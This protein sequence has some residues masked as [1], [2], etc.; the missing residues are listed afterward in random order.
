MSETFEDALKRGRESLDKMK[1]GANYD[2]YL[3]LKSE[4]EQTKTDLI[5]QM[6]IADGAIRE[7]CRLESK[8]N[9]LRRYHGGDGSVTRE[10]VFEAIGKL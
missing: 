2:E 10:Q 9:L 8:L 1:W 6:E 4:L 7:N 3:R 5:R